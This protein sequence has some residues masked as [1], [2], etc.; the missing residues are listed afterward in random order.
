MGK[1]EGWDSLES[2]LGG[3]QAKDL[4]KR[5]LVLLGTARWV[6]FLFL[7]CPLSPV[8]APLPASC[9]LSFACLGKAAAQVGL[10][11]KKPHPLKKLVKVRWGVISHI[12]KEF[13]CIKGLRG[14]EPVIAHTLEYGHPWGQPGHI[15]P[16]AF[17][18]SYQLI[19]PPVS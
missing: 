13:L 12:S 18:R 6:D 15:A 3:I 16:A 7:I 1:E 10:I 8:S 19:F 9:S 5:K 4:E 2:S 14:R 11:L 17:A